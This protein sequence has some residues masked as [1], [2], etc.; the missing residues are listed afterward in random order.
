MLRRVPEQRVTNRST[1]RIFGSK[2]HN[3]GAVLFHSRRSNWPIIRY[4][5]HPGRLYLTVFSL[6]GSEI[7]FRQTP[8]SGPQRL[9][10][11]QESSCV[12][13]PWCVHTK[14][15]SFFP[16]PDPSYL[17]LVRGRACFWLR[18]WKRKKKKEERQAYGSFSIILAT[19]A[20][21]KALRVVVRTL[22]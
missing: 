7:C 19:S 5:T 2:P 1:H 17:R 15:H 18:Y 3:D 10:V 12:W 9:E 22:P 6:P 13:V 14:L 8:R 16:A 11:G 20:S 4:A 21:G